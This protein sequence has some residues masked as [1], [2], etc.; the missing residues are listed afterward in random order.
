MEF[1][2]SP[3]QEFSGN[4]LTAGAGIR[5]PTI[6]GPDVIIEG[7]YI[8]NSRLSASGGSGPDIF[9]EKGYTFNFGG[10]LNFSY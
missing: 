5:I 6:A 9:E 3:T 2:N 4:R 1:S 10:S 8:I 7:T